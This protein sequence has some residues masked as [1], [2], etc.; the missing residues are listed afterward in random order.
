MK[1]KTLIIIGAVL[2][3]FIITNPSITAFKAYLGY[4]TYE[5]LKRP[6]NL[7]ICSVY[8]S[9]GSE[10]VG[11]FGN[12]IKVQKKNNQV[13]EIKTDPFIKYG[14]HEIK[15]IPYR[16]RVYMALKENLTDFNTP[17][18][19]FDVKIKDKEYA[20]RVYAALKDNLDGFDK[21]PDEF[22]SLV[23]E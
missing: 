2:A 6:V 8:K 22:I 13:A 4:N 12:F 18:N 16:E 20:L 5:G 14:G 11:F 17:E 7:F 15:D 23:N 1:K 9:P 19:E 21:T 10:Y 3:L